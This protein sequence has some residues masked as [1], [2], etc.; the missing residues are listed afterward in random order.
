M[1]ARNKIPPP[2]AILNFDLDSQKN[3]GEMNARKSNVRINH[4]GPSIG[5]VLMLII[6]DKAPKNEFNSNAATLELKRGT[7]AAKD[8]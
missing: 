1:Y 8:R 7:I 6:F 3:N 4:K 2:I 5:G